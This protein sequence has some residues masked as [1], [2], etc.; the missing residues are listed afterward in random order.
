IFIARFYCPDE[1]FLFDVMLFVFV[2]VTKQELFPV[3]SN[4]RLPPFQK[5]QSRILPDH[6]HQK[7]VKYQ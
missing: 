7:Y 6:L 3:I 4:D 5:V 2:R 1:A